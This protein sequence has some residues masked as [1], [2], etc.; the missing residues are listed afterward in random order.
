MLSRIAPVSLL[1]VI[2]L[3]CSGCLR[4]YQVPLH[5]QAELTAGVYAERV[6][7]LERRVLA[8]VEGID[9]LRL[10]TAEDGTTTLFMVVFDG[11]RDKEEVKADVHQIIS[12]L[13][14]TTEA[15]S[16]QLRERNETA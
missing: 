14:L 2:T 15:V 10:S 5:P 6:S 12:E 13:G 7:E 11:S 8:E 9:H 4:Y 16:I 3:F 1:V